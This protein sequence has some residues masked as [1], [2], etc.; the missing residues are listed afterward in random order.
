MEHLCVIVSLS[1]NVFQTKND[2]V[3]VAASRL[4]KNTCRICNY[5]LNWS[6]KSKFLCLSLY[7]LFYSEA[8]NEYA[9]PISALLLPGNTAPF[10]EMLQ[11]WRV[12]GN[13]VS[14]LTPQDLNHRPPAPE[15]NA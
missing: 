1:F 8:C 12:V 4:D 9:E 13:T 15:T 2:I 10:E 11:R 7:S 14:D 5:L 3:E 6:K